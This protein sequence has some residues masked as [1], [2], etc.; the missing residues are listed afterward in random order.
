MK[1]IEPELKNFQ[2]LMSSMRGNRDMISMKI[3]REQFMD[4]K[5]RHRVSSFLPL[6]GLLQVFNFHSKFQ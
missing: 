5:E 6:F 2:S 4:M 1:L 3:A